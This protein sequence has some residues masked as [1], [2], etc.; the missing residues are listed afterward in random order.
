LGWSDWAFRIRVGHGWYSL[1]HW[2]AVLNEGGMGDD[3]SCTTGC[4]IEDCGLPG[5]KIET[6]GTLP[7]PS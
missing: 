7:P 1:S 6:W 5:L 4:L 3:R 2:R